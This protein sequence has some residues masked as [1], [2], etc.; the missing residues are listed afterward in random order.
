MSNTENISG[1]EVPES[2]FE[3]LFDA[4][5]ASGSYDTAKTACNEILIP[6]RREPYYKK[7]R[8]EAKVMLGLRYLLRGS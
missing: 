5:R 2:L 8:G 3:K 6:L 1:R 4:V 7:A